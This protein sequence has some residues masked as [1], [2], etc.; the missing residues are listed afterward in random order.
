MSEVKFNNFGINNNYG[1]INDKEN[2]KKETEKKDEGQPVVAQQ[3]SAEADKVLDAL[4]LIGA[5]NFAQISTTKI[6]PARFLSDERIASIEESMKLF[7]KGVEKYAGAIK[8]EFGSNLS[9]EA[10]YALA[11]E[12]FG[13]EA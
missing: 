8:E 12:T 7:E 9:E 1:A 13:R 4:N 11:A 5:Q 10:V 2:L 6:D 3:K